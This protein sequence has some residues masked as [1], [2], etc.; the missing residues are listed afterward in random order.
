[1]KIIS[2]VSAKGGVGKTTISA[3]LCS[4][5]ISQGHTVLALDLDPQNS[6]QLHFG[7]APSYQTGVALGSIARNAW[8]EAIVYSEGGCAVLPFGQ[9]NERERTAFEGLL[10]S[11]PLILTQQLNSLDLPEDVIVI[12]D[13]PPGPSIYLKQALSVANIAIVVTLADAASYATIPMITGLIEQ[14]CTPRAD[15]IDYV[16]V[17]NQLNR[18][19]ELSGDVAD[20]MALQFSNKEIVTIHQDQSIPEALACNQDVMGYAPDSRGT[21]DLLDFSLLIKPL[22]DSKLHSLQ[23]ENIF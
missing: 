15:F 14:Y 8:S 18:S 22:L 21:H 9:V 4:A 11:D 16:H 5:L 20:I 10:S 6:L 3:N 1:V 7:I 13:T 12:I 17:L 2:V 19:R 23:N